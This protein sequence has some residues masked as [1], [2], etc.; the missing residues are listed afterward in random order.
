MIEAGPEKRKR[1]FPG[2]G[3]EFPACDDLRYDVAF[4]RLCAMY[5]RMS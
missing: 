4:A 5:H 2:D 1:G 3:E